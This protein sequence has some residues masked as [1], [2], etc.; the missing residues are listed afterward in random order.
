MLKRLVLNMRKQDNNSKMHKIKLSWMEDFKALREQVPGKTLNELVSKIRGTYNPVYV[1]TIEDLIHE[2]FKTGVTENMYFSLMPAEIYQLQQLSKTIGN[3]VPEIP[4]N[5]KITPDILISDKI[6]KLYGL[7]GAELKIGMEFYNVNLYDNSLNWKV[8]C[9]AL[10]L[11]KF[12]LFYIACN[13]Y[14]PH[15]FRLFNFNLYPYPGMLAE[16][17][18]EC[19]T[20]IAWCKLYNLEK[21]ILT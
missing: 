6:D 4:V 19:N 12:N 5:F 18:L 3:W 10:K 15:T 1:G 20:F 9:T 14:R 17:E 16:L 8:Y 21:F 2:Y 13:E 11:T 7:E